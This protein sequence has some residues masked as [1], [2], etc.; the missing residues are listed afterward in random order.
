MGMPPRVLNTK[1]R[2]E[3]KQKEAEA[4]SR[5]EEAAKTFGFNYNGAVVNPS[6][7]NRYKLNEAFKRE[8]ATTLIF[9]PETQRMHEVKV[10]RSHLFIGGLFTDLPKDMIPENCKHVIYVVSNSNFVIDPDLMPE[11]VWF[12]TIRLR[13]RGGMRDIIVDWH[14]EDL[15]IFDFLESDGVITKARRKNTRC[16]LTSGEWFTPMAN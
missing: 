4:R 15:P 7:H 6:S 13:N 1:G 11:E 14:G 5:E 9:L 3:A 8:Q 2:Q 12:F 16:R 10:V